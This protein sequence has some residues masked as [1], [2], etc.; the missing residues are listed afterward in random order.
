MDIGK[1]METCLFDCVIVAPSFSQRMF[2]QALKEFP[3]ECCGV[4]GGRKNVISS[5]YPISNDLRS[6]D[7]FKANESELFE[8]IRKM[9]KKG[10]EFI[11]IYHSHPYSNGEPSSSD[12]EQNLYPG[13][14]YFIISFPR[15]DDPQLLCYVMSEDRTYSKIEMV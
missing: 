11:G 5:V 13:H 10:E 12:C 6:S 7:N 2:D 15:K 3:L 14:F 1:P 8:V 4:L 9:R